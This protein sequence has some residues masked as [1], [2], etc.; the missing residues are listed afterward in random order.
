MAEGTCVN[1]KGKGLCGRPFCPILERFKS[2]TK[3]AKSMGNT[4][5]VFGPS[6]PS[7]F[8]GSYNYPSLSTGPLI[9]P[10][11]DLPELE[12]SEASAVLRE[13]VQKNPG[14]LEDSREWH[15][16]RMQDVIAMRTALVRANTTFKPSDA[17]TDNPLLMKAQE[18]ALSKRP[19]D[20]EAWF[21]KPVVADLKFDSMMM[22]MGPSG[23]VKDFQITENPKVPN[24]VDRLVYDTDALSKD[25]ILEL[26]ASNVS[27][28][29]ITR[30]MSI[31]LLGRDR[32]LVPTRWSITAV[33]DM[34][35]KDL[36]QRIKDYPH[37]REITLLSG[38][39]F[40][41][42]F[43]IMLLPGSFSFEILEIWMSQSVWNG[44][45][46][47]IAQDHEDFY[48]KK[49][50]S[51]LTGGYYAARLAILEYLDSIKRQA[52]I[53]AVRE[54]NQNYWAPLGVWVVREAAR[55]AVQNKVVFETKEDALAD[56]EK[57]ILTPRV[58]WEAATKLLHNR[59][60][61]MRLDSF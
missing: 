58:Q 14:L 41:N 9:P 37:V 40:G 53:F 30:L 59:A 57:R 54:I 49:E 10:S 25:A 52:F 45:S 12:I 50:Y 17:K 55:V 46:T 51:N 26:Y 33:D 6:P 15:D 21:K 7:V 22:P 32:R 19:I 1:C 29:Q 60:V 27:H 24:A 31:G 39:I 42:R 43:E 61:Q 2:N 56:M 4:T 35:G 38:E 5:S 34:S 16:L 8:V 13:K 20:T 36:I 48:G 47:Y 11:L 3:V 44:G 18:L 28:E 23:Q